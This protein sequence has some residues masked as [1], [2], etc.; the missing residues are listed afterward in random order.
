[1]SLIYDYH[2]APGHLIR[3]AHQLAVSIFAENTA[4]FEITPV[5]F[6]MLNA[7]VDEP[8]EDQITLAGKVAF[9]AATSGAVIARLEAKGLLRRDADPNDK[10]RKLLTA[11]ADGEKVVVAMKT[12][13]ADVQA[14]ILQ[15]LSSKEADQLTGLLAKLVAGHDDIAK[16]VDPL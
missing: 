5:Q 6:A 3:R 11:T 16:T 13:V 1:M 2:A 14:Q 4:A 15:P 8:G 10:R 9:D 12:A 7:L